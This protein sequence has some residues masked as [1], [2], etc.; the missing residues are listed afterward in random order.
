MISAGQGKAAHE[1]NYS[2]SREAI[3]ASDTD[4]HGLR[5]MRVDLDGALDGDLRPRRPWPG[6]IRVRYFK[7]L[8]S[9]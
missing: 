8:H 7:V 5:V 3:T 9:V 2:D 6:I 1:W 4:F